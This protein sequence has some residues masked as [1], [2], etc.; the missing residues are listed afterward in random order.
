MVEVEELGAVEALVAAGSALDEI[1]Q[2][3]GDLLRLAAHWADLHHPDSLP[4]AHDALEERRRRHVGDHGVP[5]GG[6]GTPPVLR[7][8][9]AELGVVLETSAGGAKH[10][11]GDA[12]D[13]RH[14]L[15][16]L[17]ELATAGRIRAW[18]ARQVATATRHLPREVMDEI[19]AG[20]ADLLPAL[21]WARF[22]TVLDATVRRADPGPTRAAEEEAAT[23]RFVG[24]GRRNDNGIT[25]LIARGTALDIQTFLAAVNRIADILALE[26][27]TDLVEVRRSKAVGILG[28]PLRALALLMAH[29]H[30]PDDG[31]PTHRGADPGVPA[32]QRVPAEQEERA[33]AGGPHNRDREEPDETPGP[34][35]PDG[36]G[37][38]SL[39]LTA[40]SSLDPADLRRLAAAGPRV[41]LVVHLT[42]SALRGLDPCAVA[43]VEGVGPLTVSTVR[44]W[45]RRRDVPVTVRPVVVPGEAV[46]VDAYEI[47]RSTRE[48]VRLRIPASAFPWSAC[49]SATM[50]LDHIDPYRDPGRGGP[51]GQT[52]PDNLAPLARGEHGLKTGGRWQ[53]RSPA[54]GVHLW[55][56]PHG[57]VHLVTGQGTYPLGRGGVAQT[58]WRAATPRAARRAEQQ[59]R[60][61]PA[62]TGSVLAGYLRELLVHG[63]VVREAC[64]RAVGPPTLTAR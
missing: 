4:P 17:W 18:K 29:Q 16:R 5:V 37:R 39:D 1:K 2:R 9:L 10:L 22:E 25:T 55:R 60:G 31:A 7:S 57:W 61:A 47:P 51:P 28:Q 58:L 62:Q 20:L 49:T 40:L 11:V 35:E 48:A 63:P 15:P 21:A 53:T 36:P 50:D 33:P 44:A 54:P 52:R 19:D 24:V 38:R 26:G 34:P 14:R 23:R 43:R 32:G 42:E 12:L 6:D 13:L 3:D 45:L 59:A 30:D 64:L 56:S 41:Q 8:C 46:P 27:D